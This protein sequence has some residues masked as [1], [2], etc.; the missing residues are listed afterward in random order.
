VVKAMDRYDFIIIN[1]P[2]GDVIGHLQEMELKV[3]AADR[4]R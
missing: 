4:D 3:K 2:A 1:F